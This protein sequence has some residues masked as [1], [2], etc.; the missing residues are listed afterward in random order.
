MDKK[1]IKSLAAIAIAAVAAPA[2]AADIL[3]K[4][5]EVG[6]MLTAIFGGLTGNGPMHELFASFNAVVLFFGSIVISYTVLSSIMATAHDGEVLGKKLSS[7]WVPLRSAGAIALLLPTAGGFSLIQMIVLSLAGYG[8]D[9]G[10]AV[11]KNTVPM[12]TAGAA[13]SATDLVP[14]KFLISR[15][16]VMPLAQRAAASIRCLSEHDLKLAESKKDATATRT[17]EAAAINSIADETGA[18]VIDDGAAAIAS[19]TAAARGGSSTIYFF[20]KG[21][22]F[23][24]PDAPSGCGQIKLRE[25]KGSPAQIAAAGLHSA[26]TVALVNSLSALNYKDDAGRE[27]FNTGITAATSAAAD[28]YVKYFNDGYNSSEG[29]RSQI[30]DFVIKFGNDNWMGAG[31]IY[32]K[33]GAVSTAAGGAAKEMPA[34]TAGDEQQ[35]AIDETALEAGFSSSPGSVAKEN[36]MVSLVKAAATGD[37]DG[38]KAVL[39]AKFTG[40]LEGATSSAK[41]AAAE[42]TNPIMA[43]KQIGDSLLVAAEVLWLAVTVIFA[44]LAAGATNIF[45]A[46]AGGV[47]AAAVVFGALGSLVY[48][49]ILALGAIGFTLSVYLP[50]VPYILWVSA[51]VGWLIFTFEAIVAA[52]ILA[53]AFAHPDGHDAFGKGEVG[54]MMLVSLVFRPALM[55]LSFAGAMAVSAAVAGFVNAT[56]FSLA[57]GIQSSANSFTGIITSIG[58]IGIYLAIMIQVIHKSFSMI[59]VVPDKV[60]TWVGGHTTGHADSSDEHKVGG[61]IAGGVA[62]GKGAAG[63]QQRQP[64]AGKGAAPAAPGAGAPAPAPGKNGE[65]I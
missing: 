1:L 23:G 7:S 40:A 42:G 27:K 36:S 13:G 56:Y 37:L 63:K 34:A 29:L 3:T 39:T 22:L 6:G 10:S 18:A 14:G 51:V 21:I 35:A 20:E 4:S 62:S 41:A 57:E 48:G 11:W 26:A 64:G 52:P 65:H 38:I 19:V 60:M 15:D 17:A 59:H 50:M 55:V 31:L 45:G 32:A 53:L 9:I 30:H 49:L 12:L 54:I 43:M 33:A 16:D 5:A 58:F 2:V 24:F 8:S 61:M 44:L 25:A 47:G 46:A 28:D